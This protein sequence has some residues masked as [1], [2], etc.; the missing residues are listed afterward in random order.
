MAPILCFAQVT[1][2]WEDEINEDFSFIE[3][4]DY[5]EGVFMNKWG[6]LSCDGFCPHEIDILKDNEGRIYDDSLAKF[7]SIV[8][9]SHLHYTYEGTTNAIAYGECHYAK[10][11]KVNGKIHIQTMMNISTH[12]ALHIILDPAKKDDPL[13]RVY[14]IYNSIR[15]EKSKLYRAVNGE[16]DMIQRKLAEGIVHMRFDLDFQS[17]EDSLFED[18]SNQ[19]LQHW[20]GKILVEVE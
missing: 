4:W 20:E 3:E 12:S 15:A 7:Y 10:A 16:I 18:F 6:Q 8:D 1:L 9:T 5:E 2:N 14:I 11:T 19:G 13:I 17:E